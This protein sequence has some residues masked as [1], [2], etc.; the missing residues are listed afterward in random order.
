MTNQWKLSCL[1]L[2]AAFAIGLPFLGGARS[3]AHGGD[4]GQEIEG[5]P[6]VNLF[7]QTI[8]I[9]GFVIRVDELT[10]IEIDGRDGSLEALDAFVAAHPDVEAEVEYINLAGVA[11]A[12]EIEIEDDEDDG[13]DDEDAEDDDIE[14]EGSLVGVNSA[15]QSL[16]VA[17]A[18]GAAHLTL[19][20][21]RETELEIGGA[22]VTVGQFL[23][24]AALLE[25]APIEVEYDPATMTAREVEL[26]IVMAVES[27]MVVRA[28]PRQL[29]VQPTVSASAARRRARL[30]KFRLLPGTRV[31]RNDRLVEV[32]SLRRGDQVQVS[33]FVAGGQ[34]VAPKVIASGP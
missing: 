9:N 11:V 29:T 32:Q 31:L 13:D 14:V 4:D 27:A 34:R 26:D 23:S 25:G 8:S 1:L 5:V 15:T 12:T 2:A 24:L 20:L 7:D 17:P 6:I 18:A 22:E 19:S 30:G 21:S 10:Q 3:W 28:A 16:T 33:Y